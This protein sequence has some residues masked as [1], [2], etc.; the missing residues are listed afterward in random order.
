MASQCIADAIPLL[1]E[2]QANLDDAYWEA[3]CVSVKDRF[4]NLISAVN[5]ELSELGKLSVQDH[6][7]NYEVVSAEFSL[8]CQ[9]L[10]EMQHSLDET[11]LRT[12]TALRLAE[13]LK[14]LTALIQ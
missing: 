10:G 6:N 9:A 2:L 14:S 1:E 7:L 8:A 4:Y 12:R 3:S 5:R 13:S 11:V